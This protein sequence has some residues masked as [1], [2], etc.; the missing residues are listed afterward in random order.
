MFYIELI[1]SHTVTLH[2]ASKFRGTN[3]F[4]LSLLFG[5]PVVMEAQKLTMS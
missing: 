2:E 3:G 4:S 5:L 1:K